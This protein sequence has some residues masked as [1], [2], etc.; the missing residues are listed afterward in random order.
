LFDLEQLRAHEF[1]EKHLKQKTALLRR[2]QFLP[3]RKLLILM[4]KTQPGDAGNYGVAR[5]NIVVTRLRICTNSTNRWAMSRSAWNVFWTASL[6]L[7]AAGSIS[8]RVAAEEGRKPDAGKG[9][10]D[11]VAPLVRRLIPLA[12]EKGAL[13]LDREAWSQPPPGESGKSMRD[14]VEACLLKRGMPKEWAAQQAA[15]V[16]EGSDVEQ[17]FNLLQ[18]ASQSHGSGRS[19]GSNER[20]QYFS[21]AGLAALLRL[22]GESVRI[23]VRE[24]KSP[25][26]DLE[27][28][29][30]GEGSFRLT[31]SDAAGGFLLVL[32]QARNGRF[33]A[34]YLAGDK[35]F[36]AAADS[37]SAFYRQNREYLEREIL[38][39]LHRFGV[40]TP[41]ASD[42]PDVRK[43][44]LARLRP[45]T[46]PERAEVELLLRQLD[47]P[48]H[49]KR[50]ES[51]R[52]LT[53]MWIRHRERIDAAQ[54]KADVS[55]EAAA[56]LKR[57]LTDNL[58][59]RR[60]D[61]LAAAL[62][63]HDNPGYL[64]RLIQVAP[65]VDRPAVA[66]ALERLKG[67]DAGK[68][69]TAPPDR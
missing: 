3:R 67:K 20:S 69:K 5:R 37:F 61:D 19:S 8:P 48:D 36:S 52:R 46:E 12:V 68:D 2:N 31:A 40:G 57:I 53:E 15:R 54:K 65:E 30:D 41:P 24:E 25:G 26:R 16:M 14:E 43:A 29:D 34:V 11:E 35:P 32:R 13:R 50:E 63:L 18:M 51:T 66:A 21:G 55:L 44:V 47:D 49:A 1:T 58:R 59:L 33:T 10:L 45:P 23:E 9:K 17:V 62:G 64:A 27:T 28:E 39:F 38:P 60:A 22:A 6:I 4:G 56:R 7:A 42:S